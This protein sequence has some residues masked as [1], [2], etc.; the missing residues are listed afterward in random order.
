MLSVRPKRKHRTEGVRRRCP[1][2]RIRD[3]RAAFAI[4]VSEG[5]S[6]A[7]IPSSLGRGS[8]VVTEMYYAKYAPEN[9]AKRLLRV[10]EGGTPTGTMGS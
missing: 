2:F 6:G 9:V 4:E 5:R 3:V 8:V 7:F 10:I 1:W